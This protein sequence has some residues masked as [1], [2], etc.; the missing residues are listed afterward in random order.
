VQATAL[1]AEFSESVGDPEFLAAMKSRHDVY[2]TYDH[3]QKTR[4][5]EAA[6]IKQAG[7]TAL[8]FGRFWGNLSFWDQARWLI[9]RWQKIDDFAG[10]VVP[11][12]C[13]E[14]RQNGRAMVFHL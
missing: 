3:K 2:V 7:V 5:A 6:A 12:T 8:W 11:G 1:R 9:N 13:A 10:S 4:A 14:I